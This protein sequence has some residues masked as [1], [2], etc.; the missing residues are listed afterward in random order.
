MTPV[1]RLAVTISTRSGNFNGTIFCLCQ[2]FSEKTFEGSV[3]LCPVEAKRLF[4]QVARAR[5]VA[6]GL[7]FKTDLTADLALGKS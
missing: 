5:Q 7:G 3:S 2:I 1:S 6:F 4:V